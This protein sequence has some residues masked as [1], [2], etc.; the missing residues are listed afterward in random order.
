MVVGHRDCW[1]RRVVGAGHKGYWDHKAVAVHSLV[2]D[3]E[4]G[5]IV[6]GDSPVAGNLAEGMVV[7]HIVDIEHMGCTWHLGA[8]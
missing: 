7:G 2:G 5:R 1:G 3:I 8:S 4:V 6:A